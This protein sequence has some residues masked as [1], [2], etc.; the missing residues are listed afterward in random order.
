MTIS[1]LKLRQF[2]VNGHPPWAPDF[3]TLGSI[4]PYSSQPLSNYHDQS[5]SSNQPAE[6]HH[7]SRPTSVN[8]GNNNHG[9][10]PTT[11]SGY[12]N[13]THA[14]LSNDNR[15]NLS[16]ASLLTP[17][18]VAFPLPGPYNQSAAC[19]PDG[20]PLMIEKGTPKNG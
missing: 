1:F 19:H 2:S 12:N 18:S 20:I 17:S 11:S 15:F 14:D 10:L 3:T 7:Q 16:A 6:D 4:N 8:S 13:Q 9:K 5:V